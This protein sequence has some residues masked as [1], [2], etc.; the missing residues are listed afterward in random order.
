VVTLAP[1]TSSPED[2]SLLYIYTWSHPDFQF[3][4]NST[5][6]SPNGNPIVNVVP[7]DFTH[8][9]KLDL[10]V[11]TSSGSKLEMFLFIGSAQGFGMSCSLINTIGCEVAYP[12]YIE[13]VPVSM[14]PSTTAQPI[15]F[16]VNGNL[17]LDMIGN[18]PSPD[19]SPNADEEAAL[20]VWS[21]VW[22][23]TNSTILFDTV[24]FNGATNSTT[25]PKCR[26]GSPHSS[27]ILDFDGDCLADIFLTCQEPDDQLSYHIWLND[28]AGGD[29]REAQS[30]MLPKGTGMISFG[31]V[32]MLYYSFIL[33]C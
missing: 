3:Y 11:M 6:Q 8:D 13:A 23:K 28:P 5:I 9:G 12:S 31:D 30:G 18:V 17:R 27:A 29:F 14:P 22:D 15:P 7:A 2:Q 20:M 19:S 24:P 10:L 16:D 26:L 21:N 32:G 33:Q 1:S 25:A 4:K